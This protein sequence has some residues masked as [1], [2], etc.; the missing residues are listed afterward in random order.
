MSTQENN[1]GD[2][3]NYCELLFSILKDLSIGDDTDVIIIKKIKPMLEFSQQK[4]IGDSLLN[5]GKEEISGMVGVMPTMFE[6][7]CSIEDE[8]IRKDSEIHFNALP[9]ETIK[10]PIIKDLS[11]K[12]SL[13]HDIYIILNAIFTILKTVDNIKKTVAIEKEISGQILILQSL[14][15][16]QRMVV[17]NASST[18]SKYM[19][20]KKIYQNLTNPTDHVSIKFARWPFHSSATAKDDLDD[21]V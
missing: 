16:T 4:Q 12:F 21:I 15:V 8:F 18:I 1:A 19:N 14:F 5:I 7:N 20:D 2:L 10:R 6:E 3:K 17:R 13:L 9:C 11:P